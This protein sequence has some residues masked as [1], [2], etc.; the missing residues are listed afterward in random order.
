M[1]INYINKTKKVILENCSFK[2]CK[3]EENLLCMKN[4]VINDCK[5]NSI[6]A[7]KADVK[8][9]IVLVDS[10]I[11]N[12]EFINI[13]IIH[14]AYRYGGFMRT[15]NCE[16]LNI[17]VKSLKTEA[18]QSNKDGN[19]RRI[20]DIYEGKSLDWKLEDCSIS[21]TSVLYTFN[22]V[23]VNNI[24]LKNINVSYNSFS[25]SPDSSRWRNYTDYSFERMFGED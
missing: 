3:V 10:Q 19:Y 18:Q 23:V 14:A 22:N 17:L 24:C 2:D 16:I 11:R 4:A 5:F 7:L 20:I 9:L 25:N 15:K 1:Y 6:C 13:S 12:T 21:Y 8:H